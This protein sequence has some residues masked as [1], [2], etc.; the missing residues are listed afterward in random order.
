VTVQSPILENDLTDKVL[1]W[2]TPR[3]DEMEALLHRLVDI[4]SNSFDKAGTDAVGEAIADLLQAEG[5]AVSRIPKAK[6]GDVFRAEVPGRKAN[7]YALLLG[8]RDTVFAKG[9]V[10]TRGYSRQGNLAFGPGVA[11][12][13]GGLVANIF[14]LRAINAVGGL[15]F[16]VVA[17]FT[18][19]EE[20]GS[21]SGRAE[22][23]AAAKGARA[24]FNSEPGRVSGN[25]VTGRKGG[26][27]FHIKVTGRAAHSGVNHEAGASAIEALARKIVRLHALTDYTSGI[28]TNVGVIKGGNTHN[29]VAPWAE[30]EL[31]LRFMT[32]EQRAQIVPEIEKIVRTEDVPGTSAEIEPVALFLPLEEKHS[33]DLFAVYRKAAEKVGFAVDGEFT[34]GCADSGFTAALGVPTLCGLGPVGGKAHTDDEFCRLDTLLPR[35]QA[36]AATICALA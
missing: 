23:E 17:L 34:G 21:P 29:T 19:D 5:I 13:K 28:A 30:A 25:V 35:A 20:I 18:S 27:S 31:D 14:A 26:A 10:T 22:I 3:A 6:F 4:D 33:K 12:M 15:P 36:M 7:S 11:D 16:P 8:H 9:T 24:V 32:L 1:A 2:L